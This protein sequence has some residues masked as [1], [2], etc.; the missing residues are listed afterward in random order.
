V[1]HLTGLQALP[2]RLRLAFW[3]TLLLL[4]SVVGVG[5]FLLASLENDLHREIDEALWLRASRV[6][7]EIAPE[8]EELFDP[9]EVHADLLTLTPLEEFSTPGIYVQVH[10]HA[11]A[12]LAAP[13]NLGGVPLPVT[14]ELVGGA[15]AGRTAYVTVAVGVEQIRVLLRPVES[16]G[17]VIGVVVVGESLH[18]LEFTQR[19]MRQ[20]LAVGAIGAALAC[21]LGGFWLTGRALHPVAEVTRLARRIRLTGQ[22]DQRIAESR[23][24]DELRE[25]TVTFNEM[26]EGLDRTFR[27]QREFLADASH[28]LRGPL[29]VVRGNLSLLG[30]DLP[31]DER[32]ESVQD[33]VEEVERMSR[34]ITD[35]LFLAEADAREVLERQPLDL[36]EIVME[37][38]QRAMR[39]DAGQHTIELAEHEP[40]ITLGDREHLLQLLWNLVDNALRYTPAG[41]LVRISVERVEDEAVLTVADTGIGIE[42]QDQPHV[43]ERFYRA[44]RSRP[45]QQGST[46]LGLAIVREIAE[47]QGG[48]VTLQSAPGEGSTFRLTLP[49]ISP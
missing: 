6:G 8:G 22:F 30:H 16:R 36:E 3:F 15:L 20:A 34:L 42:M 39:L 18:P 9:V 43:F 46:G 32:R 44:D 45:R 5:A 4:A 7:R 19:T 37:V 35:L 14:P 1:P 40:V 29:A 23:A 48:R 17:R 41:G 26:L 21:L 28:E 49:I 27:R 13:P 33:A 2:I 31:E 24:N 12:V 47:A 38:W 25:L 11:G 10:D